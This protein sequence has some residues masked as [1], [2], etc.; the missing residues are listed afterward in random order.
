MDWISFRRDFEAT[1]ALPVAEFSNFCSVHEV[2]P[3]KDTLSIP[4]II[5]SVFH[6]EA[7]EGQAM[8]MMWTWRTQ[9]SFVQGKK[10]FHQKEKKNL[11]GQEQKETKLLYETVQYEQGW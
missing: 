3:E 1:S 9:D 6:A 5:S 4:S 7:M 10:H 11:K 8:P 2:D